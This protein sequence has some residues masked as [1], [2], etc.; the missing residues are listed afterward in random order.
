VRKK[1]VLIR[2]SAHWDRERRAIGDGRE[3]MHGRQ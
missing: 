3:A 2:I 1:S